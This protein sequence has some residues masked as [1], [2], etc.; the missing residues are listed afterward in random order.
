MPLDGDPKARELKVEK[1]LGLLGLLPC[2]EL[3]QIVL[4]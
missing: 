3:V 2:I 1:I 4:G